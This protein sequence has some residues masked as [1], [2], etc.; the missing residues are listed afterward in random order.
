MLIEAAAQWGID[1]QAS[2]M[3]GDRWRD[4]EAGQAA[5]CKTVFVDAGYE[6]KALVRPAD[7]VVPS[8]DAAAR[9][10]IDGAV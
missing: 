10:I 4:I 5:Q 9:L 8:L 7:A 1:L 3:V 2:V 6:E